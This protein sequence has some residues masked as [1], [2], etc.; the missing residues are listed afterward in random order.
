MLREGEKRYEAALRWEATKRGE[1]VPEERVLRD[2]SLLADPN[3]VKTGSES[4]SDTVPPISLQ[5]TV[6][7]GAV[8]A[9]RLDSGARAEPSQ[10]PLPRAAPY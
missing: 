5:E 1:T 9:E 6:I 3:V 10:M 2:P 8:C 7:A 4:D